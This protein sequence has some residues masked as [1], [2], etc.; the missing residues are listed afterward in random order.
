MSNFVIFDPK[1]Y[2][3]S[4]E[5]VLIVIAAAVMLLVV[6]PAIVMTI[7]FAWRY[8]GS[9]SKAAYT[10][11]WHSSATLE[12]FFWVIPTIIVV[13]L[14]VLVWIY[15]HKL[16]PFRPIPGYKKSL[17]IQVV[18]LDWKW[19]FIYPAEN[20]AS[21]N[22]LMLPVNVPVHFYLTSGTV[23]NSFFIPNLGSQIMTMPGMQTQLNLI[24]NEEGIYNGISANFSGNG[25][26]EMSFNAIAGN[27][28]QYAEWV[29]KLKKERDILS[30]DSY[31]QLAKTASTEGVK[32]FSDVQ[33][34][35]QDYIIKGNHVR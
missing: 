33:V 29:A 34:D 9:S 18:S 27:K 17:D 15:S 1:G 7:I 20:I 31:D 2:I 19:L 11:D 8:R 22:E 26:A 5:K 21:V 23:M 35:F 28:Q 25:F 30:R 3:G 13:I 16:D 24:A 12:A 14:S 10:P 32:Y 4:N 6:I